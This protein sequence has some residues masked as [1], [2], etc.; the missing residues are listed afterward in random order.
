MIFSSIKH[1]ILVSTVCY[2]MIVFSITAIGTYLYFR[3]Q[4]KQLIEKQQFSMLCRM[5]NALDDKVQTAHTLLINTAAEL[6]HALMKDKELAQTWLDNRIGIRTTFVSGRFLFT[7]DG[8]IFVESPGLPGRRGLDLSYREYYK[9]CIATG[10]PVIS[11]PYASS[12][13]GRPTIMMTAPVYDGNGKL[14]AIMGGTIDL[15]NNSIFNDLASSRIGKKGYLYLYTRDRVMISHPDRSL[16][17][18]DNVPLGTNPLFDRSI[19]EGFEGSGETSN[20]KGMP[21]IAGF[22]RLPGTGWILASHYPTD[23]AF[24]PISRFRATYLI[25][26]SLAMLIG[27]YGAWRLANGITRHLVRLSNT[28]QSIDP[29]HLESASPIDI[30]SHDEIGT[31]TEVFNTLLKQ[32]GTIQLQLAQ[33]QEL[34]HT[35]SWEYD[36][37]ADHLSWSVETYRIFEQDAAKFQPSTEALYAMLPDDE[38][39]QVRRTFNES[40]QN[41]TP[42]QLTHRLILPDG[43]VKHLYE[44]CRTSYA[45]NGTPLRS[46]GI[47]QDIT[48]QA[49]RRQRQERLFNAISQ[50]GIYLLLVDDDHVIR[51]MNEALIRRY[52]NQIG[53]HCYEMLAGSDHS[54]SYCLRDQR[55]YEGSP[56]M[57]THPDGTVFNITT[58]PFMD[59]DGA[60]CVLELLRDETDRVKAEQA[61][62]DARQAADTAN[63]AKSEFLSNM[64]HEIRTPMN[65]VIGMAELMQFTSLTPEQQE[66]LDCIKSSGDSLLALINDILDLSKIEAG[67]IELEYGAF[68]L[69]KAINDIITTQISLAHR[70]HLQLSAAVSDRLPDLV[71]G[72]QLRVKQ[73][74][75]NLLNNAIKFT[76]QGSVT[77]QGTLIRQ[78]DNYALI[79]LSVCDTGI[80]VAPEAQDKIFAPFAQADSST[81][82]KFGGTGLG[83]TICRQLAK[84][85]GGTIQLE[86]APGHGSCFQLELPFT[87]VT[88][89]SE[90]AA[91]RHLQEPLQSETP[92][93]VLIVD[94]NAMNLQTIELILKKLGHRTVRACN[95]QEAVA[96]W[97]KESVDLIFMDIQMP[98][99]GG[100]EA[101]KTI[102][103]EELSGG[104]RTPVVA[105]TANA[106]K[107]TAEQLLE[108]GFDDYLTKPVT[109]ERIAAA[110][111]RVR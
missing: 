77:I 107:G 26:M 70:K 84:L 110:I 14:I 53:K 38:Q 91:P 42:Y 8:K 86:S 87:V 76:E 56:C 9:K 6:P 11:A 22:K 57:V 72:D 45:P 69:R 98:V 2:L 105:L 1:R 30:N 109:V 40:L 12:K 82:R 15:L 5:A 32:A 43:S 31:L 28:V 16:L 67:K 66:Y 100:V 108:E 97:R 17:F 48:E 4:T 93:T 25:V 46:I 85:M 92:R 23:E 18:K 24:E 62:D 34:T 83:L 33:A 27:S 54:C 13:H 68:S 89:S 20:Y 94:D 101:L 104:R 44:Q 111:H 61:L 19:R 99:M 35:G 58:V 21:V 64:S 55:L 95:G 60:S 79:R 102:R 39:E 80:G 90:S 74:L 36:H 47:V 52:G 71:S 65:G 41:H 3:H 78:Q 75:L 96:Q 59:I 51:Y 63:R 50:T 7:P 106:L 37:C 81:T 10:K 29:Q 49:T 88:A 103:A 73:I